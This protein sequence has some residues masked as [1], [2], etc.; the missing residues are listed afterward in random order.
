M[1]QPSQVLVCTCA[2]GANILLL[3]GAGGSF[4]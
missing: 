4:L 1:K 3:L 2:A